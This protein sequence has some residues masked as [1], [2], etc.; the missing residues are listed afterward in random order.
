VPQD[1]SLQIE[2]MK[3]KFKTILDSKNQEFAAVKD[4]KERLEAER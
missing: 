3:L 1:L 4:T 2:K